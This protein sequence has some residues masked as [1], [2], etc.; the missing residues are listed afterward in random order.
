[1]CHTKKLFLRLPKYLFITFC[2]SL[3]LMACNHKQ[4]K[5]YRVG[6][7][8]CGDADNWRKAMLSEMKTELVFHPDV[9]LI[10]KQAN[11]S[12]TLQIE[13]VRELLDSR[14][15]LLIISP[16][17]AKP[18]TPVVEEAFQRNIPVIVVDRKTASDKYTNYIGA[19]NYEI[20]NNAGLYAASLLKDSG[21]IIE[22][23]GLPASSPAIEREK[24][25]SDA[26][27]NYPH[28][29][30][31][32]RVNGDWVKPRAKEA[33]E[34]TA[35]RLSHT[36]L[37]F[38]HNDVMGQ[39]A[40]E[41]L[42]TM[43]LHD[44]I[45]IIG[46]DALH[47]KDVGMEFINTKTL[48]ASLLYPTGGAESIR[49]AVKILNKETVP[50]QTLLQTL[51]VDSTNVRMMSLQ[52][53]KILEQQEDIEKQQ[54]VMA[55]Q[56][57]TYNTQ[58]NLLYVFAATLVLALVF[59]GLLFY[60]RMLNK[61]I[62]RQLSK[63]NDEIITK[64]EQLLEMSVKEEAAHQARLNFFTNISHEFRTPLSL[65]LA[66]LE[67][68]IEQPKLSVAV[69]QPLKM[70]QKNALRLLRLLNQLID[71]RKIEFNKM[72][73]AATP[74]DI[75]AFINE[76]IQTFKPIA[77]KRNIDC[78]LLTT[79]RS[80]EM[81]ADESMLD[82]IFFN[83]LSNALKFTPD[84]GFIS[85][86]IE[87]KH[88]D[89]SVVLLVEDNG[90]GMSSEE[91]KQVFDIFYQGDYGKHKGSGLGLPLVK[92]LVDL[93]KG[94]IRVT[95]QK[96]KG[97]IFTLV[98]PLGNA[99]FSREQLQ[100]VETSQKFTAEEE[101]I[102]LA[103]LHPP[104][105]SSYMEG[106][107]YLHHKKERKTILLIEDNPE[108][109]SFL[110][111]KLAG[112]YT[113]YEAANGAE[114]TTLAFEQMPDII[115]SDVMM[116]V[117]D[118]ITL[119]QQLKKDV[120][121]AHIPIILLTARSSEQHQAEGLEAAVDAYI[122]KPF[123]AA[124]LQRTIQNLLVN[125]DKLKE[126]YSLGLPS[127]IKT[128]GKKSDR[129]FIADFKAIVEKNIANEKL[130]SDDISKELNISKIQ[131]YR[132]VKALLDTTVNEYVL[133]TRISKAKYYLQH[134]ELGMGEIAYKTGFSSPAY[135]STVF[136]TKTGQTP[137]QYKQQA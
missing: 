83:L 121:T 23:T 54:Q 86:H 37:I 131:L 123:N 6:F 94:S 75:V 10:Y 9:E 89:N 47:G 30:V 90:I 33:L 21:N 116:P 65:I 55:E 59:A 107:D 100:P 40:Y 32:Q 48:T 109:R 133:N 74:T 99:H 103:D 128:G 111:N 39:G 122:T 80:L 36:D 61:R 127:S 112:H 96:G 26:I 85:I 57:H 92:E 81:W 77:E 82:K 134:E 104:D 53:G 97:S 68:L 13:Q 3:L 124:N 119:A 5:K 17:E 51:V 93:H 56:L 43:G 14:I 66:P 31:I 78:R 50:K 126:H 29:R 15:D 24:G 2:F 11:D 19:D 101:N 12:S 73:V 113:I 58:R 63:K 105:L 136:K 95:S 132:K 108:M 20:G 46:V 87:K 102:F 125:R 38:A 115:I 45:K 49:N 106:E 60:S 52:S 129:L 70:V 25:F 98:F 42:K 64:N 130:T 110:S 79:E 44:K 118:G 27:K 62:N 114:G 18:L 71:F 1:M 69:K 91:M 34:K 137:K 84:N 8:Q 4:E 22:I 7:S 72:Q 67:E 88:L 120:R 76:I 16:N 41:V 28:I 117:K 35:T 135:F